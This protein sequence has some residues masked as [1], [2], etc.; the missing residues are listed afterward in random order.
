MSLIAQLEAAVAESD[1]ALAL[2][3]SRFD[4][5]YTPTAPHHSF[6][7][8]N[9]TLDSVEKFYRSV[10]WAVFVES[11]LYR[12]ACALL[13]SMWEEPRCWQLFATSELMAPWKPSYACKLLVRDLILSGLQSPVLEQQ[14]LWAAML[15]ASLHPAI[16]PGDGGGSVFAF[17]ET[18]TRDNT[19]ST[20]AQLFA[21]VDAVIASMLEK[22]AGA[23]PSANAQGRGSRGTAGANSP[24]GSILDCLLNSA[25]VLLK[26]Y[27][28]DQRKW[29]SYGGNQRLFTGLQQLLTHPQ[30]EISNRAA[31]FAQVL[32]ETDPQTVDRFTTHT[33]FEYIGEAIRACAKQLLSWNQ[34]LEANS[35]YEP[36]LALA[37]LY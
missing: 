5:V 28:N 23:K 21:N 30:I 33:V 16:A 11:G 12:F 1:L 25:L 20:P 7:V 37:R 3:N 32:L 6:Q 31:V 15:C 34:R 22:T 36:S 26:L 8:L 17:W 10:P 14:A 2:F 24:E 18:A 4:G 9:E 35:A 27:P 19:A 13:N 29:F